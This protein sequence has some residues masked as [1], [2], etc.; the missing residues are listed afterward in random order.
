MPVFFLKKNTFI[1]SEIQ[2]L[3]CDNIR[4]WLYL[5]SF[6]LPYPIQSPLHIFS[7]LHLITHWPKFVL[8]IVVL[9]GLSPLNSPV[10][11]SRVTSICNCHIKEIKTYSWSCLTKLE[12][13]FEYLFAYRCLPTLYSLSL[14]AYL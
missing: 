13:K 10:M 3:C 5:N 9:L 6:W 2:T 11:N 14:L 7:I 1:I 8:P 12:P 4:P